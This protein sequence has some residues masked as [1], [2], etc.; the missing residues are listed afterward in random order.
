MSKTIH[1]KLLTTINELEKL[2]RED[3]LVI[4]KNQ[5]NIIKHL[6]NLNMTDDE[7]NKYYMNNITLFISPK[8]HNNINKIL[9][10]NDFIYYCSDYEHIINN[11]F[12]NNTEIF[13]N[14]LYLFI[15]NITNKMRNKKQ[16]ISSTMKRMVWNINIGEEIGKFKCLCCKVTDITQMSF[17]CGHIIPESRG[18][19]TIVS[20]M[21]PICQNCNLS[22]GS[23]NMDE[24]MRTLE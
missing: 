20:N 12:N 3:Y 4:Y 24:F 10:L 16:P 17:H 15:S 7:Y 18:G 9:S 23:K 13:Y 14:E 22:M 1:N 21:R 8:S 6:T 2:I 19:A 5:L 11:G